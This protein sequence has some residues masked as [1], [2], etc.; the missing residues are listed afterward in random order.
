MLED[1]C[2]GLR[3]ATLVAKR[4]LIWMKDGYNGDMKNIGTWVSWWISY[5][6]FPL[7]MKDRE[8]R[9]SWELEMW[10]WAPKLESMRRKKRSGKVLWLNR[11]GGQQLVASKRRSMTRWLCIKADMAHRLDD[12]KDKLEQQSFIRHVELMSCVRLVVCF[13]KTNGGVWEVCLSYFWQIDLSRSAH[14]LSNE[15]VG[16]LVRYL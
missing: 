6:F 15:G 1:G 4:R 16:D 10:K 2:K 9:M 14:D 8:I 11:L 13:T 5:S 3:M 12:T 7:R